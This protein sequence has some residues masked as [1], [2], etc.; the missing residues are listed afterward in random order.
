M[1]AINYK[2][3]TKFLFESYFFADRTLKI[4]HLFLDNMDKSGMKA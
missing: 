3:W 4:L 1:K 2:C